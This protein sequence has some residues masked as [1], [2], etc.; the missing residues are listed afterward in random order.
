M[1][2]ART[3]AALI[4]TIVPSFGQNFYIKPQTAK[5]V[6]ETRTI[7]FAPGSSLKVENING[8]IRVEAWDKSEVQFTGEF[9][10]NS[11]DEQVRV[12]VEPGDGC[13]VIRGEFPKKIGWHFHYYDATC[14]MTLMVPRNVMIKLDTVKGEITLKGTTGGA[15]AGSVQGGITLDQVKGAL[16]LET[17]Q[18]SIKGSNLD[19]M[20]KNVHAESVSGS[21]HLQFENL[22][23]Y[24]KTETV[25][26]NA[27]VTPRVANKCKISPMEWKPPFPPVAPRF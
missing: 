18:G 8:S 6:L 7:P 15:F 16:N 11:Q 3:I 13:L 23:G 2:L 27:Q 12:V 21:I 24:V 5:K 22:K 9:Q 20:G 10:P 14:H 17:V 19:N 1:C 4:L 26:G 25:S